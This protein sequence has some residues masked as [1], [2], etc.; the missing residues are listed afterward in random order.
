MNGAFY[1]GATG[2]GAQQ[3]ALD[4]VANNIANINTLGFKRSAIRFSELVAPTRDN[5]DAPVVLPERT[6]TLS[7]VGVNATPHIWT[8]G[9]LRQTGQQLDVAIEGEGFLETLGS[10]G[11]LL[12][13]RGGTLKVN[14]DGYL[15]AADG[16]MLRAMISVPQGAGA[17]AIGRDGVVTARVE[18]EA[19]DVEIGQLELVMVKDKDSLADVGG[20]YYEALDG[21]AIYAVRPGEEGGGALVQGAI[22]TANV[23]LSDEMV[24]LLLLQRAYAA[25]AQVVQA[26][27]QLMSIT[28]SL[29]R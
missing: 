28:N 24:T 8:Q 7:G 6:E 3:R 9:D 5:M 1:I 4:V 12:L 20:G 21:R 11:R 27:D 23:Q 13:W 16:T 10:S 18:G 17:L 29:R 25:N 22:E 26:G 19:S 14:E 15:A 2:L